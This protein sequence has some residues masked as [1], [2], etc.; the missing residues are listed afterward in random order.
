V[1]TVFSL[2]GVGDSSLFDAFPR[3]VGRGNC[4][5]EHGGPSAARLPGICETR[6]ERRGD[7][8]LVT[9]VE[10]WEARD[11]RADGAAATGPLSH[12]WEFT[13]G[14]EGGIIGTRNWGDFPPQ[15]VL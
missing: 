4:Q 1:E 9:L 15:W 2:P 11:F 7:T 13:L 5:I 10:T 3:Q 6:V 14:L 12:T 8:W